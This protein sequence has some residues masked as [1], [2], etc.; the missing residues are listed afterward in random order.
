[1]PRL[2]RFGISSLFVV[3]LL[4]VG[5]QKSLAQTQ[6]SKITQLKLENFGWER[7]PQTQRGEWPGLG[8][9][10]LSI[11][12]KGRVLVGFTV[13]EDM[14]LATREHPGFSF[15]ILRFT[16]EGKVDLSLV[17]PTNT[18]FTNG[19]YLGPNDQIFARA[20]DAFQGI[21]EEDGSRK[22]GAVWRPIAPCPRDCQISQSPSR[23]T[24][25]VTAFEHDYDHATHTILDA[26]STPP[27]VI[28]I[29]PRSGG[30]ITDKYSYGS[31]SIGMKYFARRSPICEPE[32][33]L[34]LPLDPQGGSLRALNDES[35]LLLGIGKRRGIELV[36][37][38][39]KVKFRQEMPKYDIVTE[40]VRSD[41]LG[42]R[43]AF[44]VETWRGGS[45]ALD[46][47]GNRVAR[48]VVVYT[49]TG[50]QLAT[51]QVNPVLHRDFDF[52]MSSDGHRLAILDEGSVTVIDLE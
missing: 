47:S 3:V 2:F 39:G 24:L 9:Q 42:D 25:I 8:S 23:R 10:L 43:V 19:L 11:D 45:R 16:S 41:A 6:P 31:G 26:S 46:I 40:E 15:H 34:E 52:S 18:L 1:M 5:C 28:Q 50:Q 49:D 17:L 4:T 27:R 30:A 20:N 35:L 12:H 22:E 44:I 48:R 38:D 29:C 14:K 36:T 13:R 51:A 33:S 7:L 37:P 21:S 32:R